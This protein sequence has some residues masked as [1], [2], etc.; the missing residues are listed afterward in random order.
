MFIPLYIANTLGVGPFILGV[1]LMIMQLA[2]LIAGPIAGIFSDNKGRRTIVFVGLLITTII[3]I[4]IGMIV[5]VTLYLV[6]I[7]ILGF[8]LFAVR[9]VIHSWL[10]DL[11]PKNLGG[12]ATSL[13]FATQSALSAAVPLGGGLIADAYGLN[14]VFYLLAVFIFLATILVLFIPDSK[15]GGNG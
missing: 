9:P 6:L 15:K 13:L 1:G 3:T 14:I 12:S 2:G 10:M 4:F 7:G 5:N 8:A 11:T